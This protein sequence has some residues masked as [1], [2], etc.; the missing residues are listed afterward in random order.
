[1]FDRVLQSNTSQEQVYE[2]CAQKIVKGMPGLPTHKCGNFSTKCWCQGDSRQIP[3]LIGLACPHTSTPII[4]ISSSS[5][6]VLDGYNGTI[7]AYGQTSS[8]KTHTMEVRARAS[9]E[10]ATV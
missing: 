7:F 4:S 9:Y 10:L 5:T 2:A 1:M 6:D 8:G 3:H